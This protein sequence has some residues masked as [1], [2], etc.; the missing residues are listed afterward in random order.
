MQKTSYLFICFCLNFSIFL[1]TRA[2]N[3]GAA[4]L[5]HLTVHAFHFGLELFGKCVTRIVPV[6]QIPKQSITFLFLRTELLLLDVS[7]YTRRRTA[8]VLPS[9]FSGNLDP[10]V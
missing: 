10:F 7:F 1:L 3:G 2:R 9:G 4:A 6:Q 5:T 8:G